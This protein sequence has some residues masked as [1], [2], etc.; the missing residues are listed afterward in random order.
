MI[1]PVSGFIVGVYGVFV[2]NLLCPGSLL[3]HVSPSDEFGTEV[4]AFTARQLNIQGYVVV[5]FL[6]NN[7]GKNL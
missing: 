5:G 3:V 2:A 1:H 4:P 7:N 6:N